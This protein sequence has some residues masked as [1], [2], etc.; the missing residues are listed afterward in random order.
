VKRLSRATLPRGFLAAG[1]ACGLKKS[2]KADLALI[3][4]RDPCVAAHLST[5]NT[6]PAAPVKLNRYALAACTQFYGILANSGNANAFTGAQGLK[7]AV[8]MRNAAAKA[9]CVPAGSVFVCSTGIINRRLAVH[10]II[11]ALPKLSSR[12]RGN[13]IDEALSAIMTTD[14]FA[15][16]CTVRVT[17]AGVPV[18]VCGIAKG[19]GMIS[20]RMATM[21]CFITTDA[22]VSRACL[23]RMLRTATEQTF[24]RTTVDGC[25]STN[26]TVIALANGC[27]GNAQVTGGA[28][29]AVLQKALTFVCRELALMMVRDGEGATKVLTIEVTG[30]RT[31]SDARAVAL[32]IANSNLVKTAL[33]AAS[34]N[35]LGR[36]VAAVG[37]AQA[38]VCEDQLR[39]RYTPLSRREVTLGVSLGRGRYA[40]TVYTS[41]L[42]HEYVKINAA[43]N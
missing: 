34:D 11:A 3:V 22:S 38:A 6:V 7:D 37:A 21:L 8:A 42:T 19:A 29:E 14:K 25:M 23:A 36:V 5:A 32:G 31:V 12:L 43:Y 13:G 40:W 18:T 27:A 17:V 24:N 33:Y 30:A 15:K 20:P 1:V 2:G 35:I 28:P 26:D 41:D 39:I 4:S 9:L 16:Q 10:K